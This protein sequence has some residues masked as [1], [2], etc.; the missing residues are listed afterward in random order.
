M[1]L[2][3][4]AL[5]CAYINFNTEYTLYALGYGVKAACTLYLNNCHCHAVGHGSIVITNVAMQNLI[6]DS[7]CNKSCHL[8]GWNQVSLQLRKLTT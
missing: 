5:S 1:T 6:L 7:S 4:I 8:I 2:F 3:K